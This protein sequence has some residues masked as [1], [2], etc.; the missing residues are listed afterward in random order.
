MF[1]YEEAFCDCDDIDSTLVVHTLTDGCQNKPALLS[2]SPITDI[3]GKKTVC[4][5]TYLGSCFG[6]RQITW[7]HIQDRIYMTDPPDFHT[8]GKTWW[9]CSDTWHKEWRQRFWCSCWQGHRFHFNTEKDTYET[10]GVVGVWQKKTLP[11]ILMTCYAS[12]SASFC[13]CL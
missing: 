8:Q 1:V 13:V 11:C 7:S 10:G 2:I 3:R 6:S 5:K 9:T 4:G 12:M